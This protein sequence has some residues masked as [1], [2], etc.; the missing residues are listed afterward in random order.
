MTKLID[1]PDD[2]KL[3]KEKL[4]NYIDNQFVHLVH[5]NTFTKPN[6]GRIVNDLFLN[7]VVTMEEFQEY[8][9]SRSKHTN[10]INHNLVRS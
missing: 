1:L 4:F 6:I 7:E 10:N 2:K 8:S 3:K 5:T 9:E